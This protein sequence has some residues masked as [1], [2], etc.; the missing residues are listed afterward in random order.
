MRTIEWNDNLSVGVQLIDEQHKMLIERLNDVSQALEVKQGEREII[1]TLSFLIEYTDFHFSAE[2]KHM[3][4]NNYPGLDEQKIQHQEF[5]TMLKTL[6]GDFEEEGSTPALAD[7]INT[8][9]L[10]WL[11][12][13]IQG[14]DKKFGDFLAE[15]GVVIA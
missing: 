1:K 5:I 6:E 7:A 3:A 15:K 14:L 13:H 12:S 11:T 2:E 9:L 10:N 8:F 4:E